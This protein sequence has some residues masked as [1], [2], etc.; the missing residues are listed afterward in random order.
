MR[1]SLSMYGS[2]GDVE[3]MGLVGQLWA[4][5]WDAPVAAGVMPTGGWR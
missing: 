2:R 5:E 4:E 3:P 1:V